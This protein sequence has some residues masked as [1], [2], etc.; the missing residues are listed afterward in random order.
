MKILCFGDS[1]TYGYDP[2]SFFGSQYSAQHRWVDLLAQKLNCTAVNAGENGR[3]IP[4]REGELMRFALM[5]TNQKPIDLLIIM[6]GG[7]DLLQGNSVE[8]V[9]KRMEAFLEHIDLDN[10]KILLIGPPP[11]QR[12]EWVPTQ[13]LID[14][15]V[16]LN[17][18][19]KSLS[20]RIAVGFA[21]AGEWNIP[22]TF[23]GVHFTEEG[24]KAF[25]VELANYL[26][27]G[28]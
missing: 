8:V 24:H 12:G 9:V 26:N 1:N 2:R 10:S 14:A 23:D 6:L 25:A 11:M 16:A 20:E 27:K 13:T 3:E 18:E 4:R 22:L 5:L 7:N 17:Y 28:E 19:Y 15:S 21:N